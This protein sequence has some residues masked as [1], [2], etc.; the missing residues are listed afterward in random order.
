[1]AGIQNRHLP[2]NQL[3]VS[4]L[5]KPHCQDLQDKGFHWPRRGTKDWM[6][7]FAGMTTGGGAL[8]FGF[9]WPRRGAQDWMPAFAGMTTAGGIGILP[10]GHPDAAYAGM[11]GKR[12]A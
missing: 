10:V 1:M 8:A 9:H 11:T 12:A 5:S 3:T 2:D 7:A 4:I 6:P